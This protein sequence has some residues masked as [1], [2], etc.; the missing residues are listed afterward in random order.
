MHVEAAALRLKYA[1]LPGSPVQKS[2]NHDIYRPLVYTE[3]IARKGWI[4]IHI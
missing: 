4:L 2:T 3:K 1:A